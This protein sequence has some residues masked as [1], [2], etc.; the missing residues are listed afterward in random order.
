MESRNIMSDDISNDFNDDFS[1]TVT[2]EY[3]G[4]LKSNL[5]NTVSEEIDDNSNMKKHINWK[6]EHEK[7]LADWADKAMCY[8]WLHAKS[9]RIYDKKNKNCTI[10]V[11]I[12][13]TLTGTANFAQD[14]IP[15][16]IRPWAQ[17]GIGLIN[18]LAGIITTISQFLKIAELNEAHRVS[19]ISWDKFSRNIKLE[20]SKTRKERMY[21]ENMLKISKEEFDRLIETSPTINTDI[22]K[23]FDDK[24][25]I[26]KKNKKNLTKDMLLKE[27]E[28]KLFYDFKRPEICN[29][30]I[31]TSEI[32]S[33][34]PIDFMNI[35][36]DDENGISETK[37]KETDK[38]QI[39]LVKWSD[40]FRELH[41]R[42]PFDFEIKDNLKQHMDN[43]ILDKLIKNNF[44][45][46]NNV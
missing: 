41:S 11:I 12:M 16:N 1:S 45:N 9:H 10:P 44:G 46:D 25:P 23:L 5:K 22:I 32:L 35:D 19:S 33:N 28:R 24:F 15:E 38:C 37:K 40:R 3:N 42:D 20:L 8:R 26:A 2:N 39:Q 7:I 30:L 4:K 6:L 34:T 17:M 29:Q 21:V 14:R 36:D 13:S 27:E 18:L 31:S 43:N